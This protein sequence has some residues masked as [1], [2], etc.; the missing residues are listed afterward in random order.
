MKGIVFNWLEEIVTAEF[1]PET[2]EE[3]LDQAGSDGIYA[4]FGSY[5]DEEMTRLVEITAGMLG[6]TLVETWR[7]LGRRAV[8]LMAIHYPMSFA[9]TNTLRDL[10]LS[11]PYTMDPESRMSNTTDIFSEFTVCEGENEALLVGYRA[12][13]N[14]CGLAEGLADGA[15]EYFGDAI[16]IDQ[17]KCTIQEDDTCLYRVRF[18]GSDDQPL[19]MDDSKFVLFL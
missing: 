16:E 11:L 5:P 2:W 1:D 13:I 3:L 7:W 4:S 18:L 10:L 12:P 19:D 17:L 6:K 14:L 15:A 9:A 8:P